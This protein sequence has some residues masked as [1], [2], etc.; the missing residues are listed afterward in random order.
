MFSAKLKRLITLVIAAAIGTSGIVAA[1]QPVI[2]DGGVPPFYTW[3][4]QVPATPGQMLR[5][6]PL[7][8]QQS[9][10]DAGQNIRILYTSTDEI[11]RAHV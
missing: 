3:T 10:T 6:E 7:T 9:L 2:G 4:E 1:S 11:G 8:P 5:T